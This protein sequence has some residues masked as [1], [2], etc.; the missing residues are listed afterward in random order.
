MPVDSNITPELPVD[1]DDPGPTVI[2]PVEPD[3]A[4]PLLN[5]TEPE[6][7]ALHDDPLPMLKSPDVVLDVP[8]LNTTAPLKPPTDAPDANRTKPLLPPPV[9]PL[10]NSTYPLLP[11]VNAFAL[12]TVTAPDDDTLPPPLTTLT[13]PPVLALSVELPADKYM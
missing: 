6:S 11:D 7:P 5:T 12:R 8:L 13:T 1:I 10:L 4:V 9:L 3:R 2:L